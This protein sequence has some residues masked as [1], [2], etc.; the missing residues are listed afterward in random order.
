LDVATALPA[1]DYNLIVYAHNART[2]L[3]SDARTVPVKITSNVLVNIDT[4]VNN[5]VVPQTFTLAGWALDFNALE[6]TGISTIHVYA[7]PTGGASAFQGVPTFG[8]ARPD[9]V[10][11]FTIASHFVNCGFGLNI[12][13]APGTYDLVVYPGSAVLQ[14]FAFDRAKTVHITVQ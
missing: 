4:P 6:G 11:F 3:F 13:L 12:T 7:V 14:N 8:G 5:A 10:S 2:G 9:V 1:G